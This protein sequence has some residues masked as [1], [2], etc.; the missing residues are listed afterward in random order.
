MSTCPRVSLSNHCG[1][2]RT[3][4][5][6]MLIMKAD[7]ACKDG[8]DSAC[9]TAAKPVP[10]QARSALFFRPISTPF[11]RFFLQHQAWTYLLQQVFVASPP[12]QHSPVMYKSVMLQGLVQ[13]SA[14]PM[15]DNERNEMPSISR[16]AV[17]DILYQDGLGKDGG[18][19][20]G[21]V[22]VMEHGKN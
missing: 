17:L 5:K 10:S 20:R 22:K 2:I 15:Y 11:N 19:G 18:G 4:T 12:M 14:N 9:A 8:E 1:S 6:S 3:C 16:V 7:Q 21:F 13:T